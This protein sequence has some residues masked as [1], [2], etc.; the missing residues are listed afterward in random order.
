MNSI[1]I[2]C[3]ILRFA[4]NDRFTSNAIQKLFEIY[5]V[6]LHSSKKSFAVKG[7]AHVPYSKVVAQKSVLTKTLLY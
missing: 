6:I 2:M 4:V 3:K 7:L 1:T 5:K